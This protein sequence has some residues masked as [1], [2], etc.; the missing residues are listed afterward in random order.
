[1]DAAFWEYERSLGMRLAMVT[2]A[3][4]ASWLSAQEGATLP[5]NTPVQALGGFLSALN[6]GNVALLAE[7]L[8]ANF[9]VVTP[10]QKRFGPGE[11]LALLLADLRSDGRSQAGEL[12]LSVG[13]E[14]A[15]RQW[16]ES[17]VQLTGPCQAKSRL[18]DQQ[19]LILSGFYVANLVLEGAQW[20]VGA[21]SCG[22]DFAENAFVD[23]LKQRLFQYGFVG[24]AIGGVVG[25]L[26]GAIFARRRYLNSHQA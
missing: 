18:S 19:P 5:P 16:S 2:V 22:I 26:L 10:F 20:K 15:M 7:S 8:A 21:F 4:V 9:V 24:L 14:V 17:L 13:S 6:S 25:L 12:K 11:G 1:M 3:L 23:N